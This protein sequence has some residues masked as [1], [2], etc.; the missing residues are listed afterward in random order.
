MSAENFYSKI[1]ELLK[2]IYKASGINQYF[3]DTAYTKAIKYYEKGDFLNARYYFV[4]CL[5]VKGIYKFS[6]KKRANC[7]N[8]LAE[9]SLKEKQ[10]MEHVEE[11]GI[12]LKFASDLVPDDPVYQRNAGGY[13]A[14]RGFF[15]KALPYL[16]K[17][18]ESEYQDQFT[19]KQKANCVHWLGIIHAVSSSEF[20]D[21]EKS[22]EYHKMSI[23]IDPNEPAY[24]NALNIATNKL[25]S[26]NHD[27]L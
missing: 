13:F 4:K 12:L 14:T 5:E 8:Y 6:V 9:I 20:Y 17:C 21:L 3:P 16:E 27:E 18:L 2:E 19:F 10:P 22:I 24:V 23:E 11:V 15:K 26:E 7:A 25:I 1:I